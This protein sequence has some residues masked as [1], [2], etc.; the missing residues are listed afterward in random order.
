MIIKEIIRSKRT[1]FLLYQ[2][3]IAFLKQYS[4]T[5]ISV[6]FSFKWKLPSEQK[7]IKYY[8]VTRIPN[9]TLNYSERIYRAAMCLSNQQTHAG[10]SVRYHIICP[11][12]IHPSGTKPVARFPSGSQTTVRTDYN[13]TS[14]ELMPSF[15]VTRGLLRCRLRHQWFTPK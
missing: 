1:F 6:T 5:H 7:L 9:V 10:N 14:L 3:W 8:I 11:M 13:I 12:T 4:N 2:M 15:R